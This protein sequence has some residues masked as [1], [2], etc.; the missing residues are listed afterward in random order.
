ME[1]EMIKNY[2]IDKVDQLRKM[3]RSN[4]DLK[5]NQSKI[6]EIAK[7][8]VD[9][10]VGDQS[11]LPKYEIKLNYQ[12]KKGENIASGKISLQHLKLNYQIKKGENIASGQIALQH[13]IITLNLDPNINDKLQDIFANTLSGVDF[14]DDLIYMVIKHEKGHFEICPKD[15]YQDKMLYD[16]LY[17]ELRDKDSSFRSLDT[18]TQSDTA[19]Y[20]LS[21]FEDIIVNLSNKGDKKFEDGWIFL[22]YPMFLNNNKALNVFDIFVKLQAKFLNKPLAH[23]FDL[24]LNSNSVNDEIKKKFLEK[25]SKDLLAAFVGKEIAEKAFEKTL[26]N[27]EVTDTISK[28]KNE[29]N[30]RNMLL[31]FTEVISKYYKFHKNH[32]F[33]KNYK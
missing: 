29:N 26:N 14:V 15:V 18:A 9:D 30:W 6:E 7:K 8:Y 27:D 12:I 19:R 24:D 17:K 2:I 31:Q 3:L 32:K 10:Q 5:I 23:L 28:L 25:I 21:I 33:H 20:C 22:Y 16:L 13:Q 1:I 11:L 4:D